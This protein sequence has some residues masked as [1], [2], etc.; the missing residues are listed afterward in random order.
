MNISDYYSSQCSFIGQDFI[1][2]PE[3]C[4]VF[5]EMIAVWIISQILQNNHKEYIL[6]EL[7]AGNG[8]MMHDILCA[9]QIM[10]FEIFY[11]IKIIIYEKSINLTNNQVKKLKLFANKIRWIDDLEQIMQSNEKIINIKNT[12]NK[13]YIF[14]ANE[15]LDCLLQV[16]YIYK[17]NKFILSDHI[18]KTNSITQLNLKE[19]I[20]S[21]ISLKNI[22]SSLNLD[23]LLENKFFQTYLNSHINIEEG[24]IIE[25]PLEGIALLE[26][27]LNKFTNSCGLFIDYGYYISPHLRCKQQYFSTQELIYNHKYININNLSNN[28]LSNQTLNNAMQNNNN[29]IDIAFHIDFYCLQKYLESIYT[30]KTFSII[31]Q[32]QFLKNM[33]IDIRMLNILNDASI[34]KENKTI[35]IKSINHLLGKAGRVFKVFSW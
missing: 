29:N 22:Y 21:Q 17:N 16:Q 4:S 35:I 33:G 2:S 7:G 9:I 26:Y 25:L 31:T 13:Y 30:D 27:L 10:H 20:L 28:N 5:S 23:K 3:V 1:T 14:I 12:N 18:V 24:S 11:K 8:T 19:E 15:F 32:R 6:V 34:T